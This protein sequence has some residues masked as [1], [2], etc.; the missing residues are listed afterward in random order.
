MPFNSVFVA[1]ILTLSN[2]QLQQ[3]SLVWSFKSL[4]I[5]FYLKMPFACMILI[6][7]HSFHLNFQSSSE[8]GFWVTVDIMPCIKLDYQWFQIARR[9]IFV[10][11]IEHPV[12]L[13]SYHKFW[14]DIFSLAIH[15]VLIYLLLFT[16]ATNTDLCSRCSRKLKTS[17]QRNDFRITG[18]LWRNSHVTGGLPWQGARDVELLFILIC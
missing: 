16:V 1:I 15:C 5:F 4:S 8:L 10:I 13:D 14:F 18:P 11:C 3:E 17:W 6:L 2:C 12:H 9:L 7:I